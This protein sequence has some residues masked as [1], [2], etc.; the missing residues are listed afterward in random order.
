MRLFLHALFKFKT[1][2]K[3]LEEHPEIM[4]LLEWEQV[5]HRT[6]FSR[7]YKAIY[8]VLQAFILFV[9]GQSHTKFN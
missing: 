5:P 4:G 1:Q 7:R 6:T 2:R 3:W 9:V 8:P